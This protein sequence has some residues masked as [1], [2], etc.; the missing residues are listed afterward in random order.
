MSERRMPELDTL[1]GPAAPPRRNGEF[2]V[3][4]TK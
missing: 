4:R 1:T 2:P 3:P